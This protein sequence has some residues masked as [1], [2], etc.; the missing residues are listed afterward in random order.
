LGGLD[1]YGCHI[2][3]ILLFWVFDRPKPAIQRVIWRR[4]YVANGLR[5]RH[6]EQIQLAEPRHGIEQTRGQNVMP[7]RAAIGRLRIL[8]IGERASGPIKKLILG[9]LELN[10]RKSRAFCTDLGF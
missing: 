8:P 6:L 1:V 7:R 3:G 5:L 9:I 4:A 2:P 10:G